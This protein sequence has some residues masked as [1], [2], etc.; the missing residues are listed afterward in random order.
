MGLL[1]KF[2]TIEWEAV[3]RR[4]P[5]ELRS[6]G[7]T[8]RLEAAELARAIY[9][10]AKRR[11]FRGKDLEENEDGSA[12]EGAENKEPSQDKDLGVRRSTIAALDRSRETLGQHLAR[13]QPGQRT[14]GTHALRRHIADEFNRLWDAQKAFHSELLTETNKAYLADIIFAQRPVFWRLNTLGECRL[15]PGAPL[16]AKGSWLSMQRRMLE[17]LNNI[18]IEG[19]NRRPLVAEERA[20][21]LAHL[22]VQGSM[23]FV[24]MRR[25]LEPLFQARGE[26]ARS[27]KFNLEAAGETKTPGN[28]VEAKLAAIF[29]DDWEDHPHKQAIRVATEDLRAADYGKIGEQRAVIKRERER[30][31][32]RHAI[33]ATFAERFGASAE[34]VAALAQLSFPTGWDAFSVSAL[35]KLVPELE[36]GVKMGELLN[37]PLQAEWHREHFPNRVQATGEI[38]DKLQSPA[39]PD[40][41]A[42][43]KQVRNPTVVRVQNEL[44]K[45]VNNLIDFCGRKPDLIRIELARDVGKGQAERAE[46]SKA[47][48][49]QEKQRKAAETELKKAGFAEPSRRDVEKWL[50]WKEC[51]EKCPYTG[52]LI[53][54]DQLFRTGEFEVEHIWPRSRSLDD[55]YK[56]KTLCR[57]DINGSKG[58]QTPFEFFQ[59]DADKWAAV[60]DRLMKMM[61]SKGGAG[62]ARSKVKWFLAEAIPDD[63]ASRQLNDTGY[64]AR[65][66]MAQLKRLWPDL[67]PTAPVTVQAVNGKV[68]AHL[69]KLW[70]LN[71][72]LGDSGEKNR[73][74]HRHHAVDAL[75]VACAA[76][77]VTNRLS[78]YWQL[79]DDP[80]AAGAEAPHIAPPWTNIR[81]DA[82]KAVAEIIVSHR[83][84]KKVS[85]PLHKET[86]Y[87]DTGEVKFSGTT[88]LALI[89][90]RIA[91]TDLKAEDI[92]NDSIDGKGY[93]IRD[94][95]TRER[96]RVHVAAHDNNLSLAWKSPLYQGEGGALIKKVKC[97]KGRQ[98]ATMRAA[99]NG[100]VDPEA[101]HHLAIVRYPNGSVEGRIASLFDVAKRISRRLPIVERQL[102][103]GGELLM[104]VHKGETLFLSHDGHQ[105]WTVR[106][107]KSNSQI[108]LAPHTE[109]RP[110][111]QAKTFK[112]TAKSLISAGARKVSVD[113]IGRVRK[114]ND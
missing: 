102:A 60:Q 24:A 87:G 65:Q 84:R 39:H 10:L 34:Q 1:P 91:L 82:E 70:G 19:G 25:L 95:K 15:E 105:Y 50:L 113:P 2:G 41:A 93:F 85:G 66:A 77:G 110:T 18:E 57:K 59:K 35:E 40:E 94:R 46:I 104:T 14:R 43:M 80:R 79:K 67:G 53:S 103:G 88:E 45:V 63:F 111:K 22:Q 81:Q 54:F 32:D 17:R 61:A 52:D 112:P 114:A 47:M 37:S 27:V 8:E 31:Q 72:L 23:T 97:V 99:H 11:H 109:A 74:D 108:T 98:K 3:M 13:T 28:P 92:W 7:L 9:H 44:R 83:V 38:L 56:N 101:K 89:S 42:R 48:R 21:I 75:T 55:S 73:G 29:G 16:A 69:R 49:D 6:R 86:V 26:S 36:K 68:T 107:I 5:I 20:A 76:P 78:R 33:A 30:A 12:F 58:N 71:N 100:L 64:A 51:G 62:M 4:N 106:E 96:I 90:E